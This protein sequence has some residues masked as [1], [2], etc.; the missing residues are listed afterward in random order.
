MKRLRIWR[1]WFAGKFGFASVALRTLPSNDR[2][3]ADAIRKSR[4][5]LGESGGLAVRSDLDRELPVTG[6][7]MLGEDPDPF[8]FKF[9]GLLRNVKVLEEAAAGRGLFT[10]VPER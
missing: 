9:A 4:V 6:F 10:I 1:R 2:S 7:A 5:V 8:I 3:F